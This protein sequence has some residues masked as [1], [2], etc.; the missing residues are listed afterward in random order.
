MGFHLMLGQGQWGSIIYGFIPFGSWGK[1][2]A[3][4]MS[5]L[6]LQLQY[7]YMLIYL[8]FS[9]TE[10]FYILFMYIFFMF[11]LVSKSLT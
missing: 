11:I 9:L 4:T 8:F 6:L 3:G 2:S 7:S 1:I 5:C 10:V